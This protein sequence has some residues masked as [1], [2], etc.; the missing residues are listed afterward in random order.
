MIGEKE[1]VDTLVLLGVELEL[2]L[3]DG[4]VEEV[5]DIRGELEIEGDVEPEPDGRKRL[6]EVEDESEDVAVKLIPDDCV[7]ESREVIDPVVE[8]VAVAVTEI[9]EEPLKN[10]DSD[11]VELAEIENEVDLHE[12]AVKE[13]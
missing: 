11:V 10:D 7:K 13:L 1:G 5:P 8:E 2:P 9:E 3:T 12:L 4:P 6:G